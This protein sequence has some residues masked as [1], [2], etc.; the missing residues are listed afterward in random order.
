MLTQGVGKGEE[1]K[2]L[3]LVRSSLGL[4]FASL[5]FSPVNAADVAG[6]KVNF[7]DYS[8]VATLSVSSIDQFKL[9]INVEPQSERNPLT[10]LVELPTTGSNAWPFIDVQVLDSKEL[11]VSVRRSGIE[12][13][14]LLISVPPEQISFVVQVVDSADNR[15][16]FPLEKERYAT[17]PKTRMSAKICSWYDGRRAAFSIRFDDSHPTHLSKAIPLLNEYG[18]RGTFMVNPGGHPPDR[19]QR[20]AFEDHRA[21]WEAVAKRGNHEFA[22]HTMNHRGAAD[23]ESMEHE[24]GDA[25]K[26]IWKLFPEKSKLSALNLGGGT[27]WVTTRPLQYY[28]DKYH[29]FDASSNSTGMDD[30]YGNRIATFRRLLDAHIERG[31]WYKVHYHYIGDGL[32]TSEA[33]F[34]AALDIA[35]NHQSQLWIAGMADIYKYQTER[36]GARLSIKNNI[37]KLSCATDPELYDQLLTID[38]MPPKSWMTEPVMVTNLKG[39]KIDVRKVTTS[40]GVVLRFDVP[41]TDS[42]YKIEKTPHPN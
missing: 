41:P 25:A 31:L 22:N 16:P 35:K 34:R 6:T 4:L 18:F 11:P 42:M 27:Q 32:S 24:I 29:H 14:K 21:E 26:A 23:D 9:Q 3:S 28:L 5:L 39:Q 8:G 13:H 30:S 17:D 15:P 33:N 1:L 36:R 19:R 40:D 10:L 37:L 20:S 38:V 7:V 2:P 12:W